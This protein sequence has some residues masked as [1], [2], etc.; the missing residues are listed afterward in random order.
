M[1][2]PNYLPVQTLELEFLN[3]DGTIYSTETKISMIRDENASPISIMGE[4]RDIAERKRIQNTLYES[5]RYYRALIE[6]A[7][8]CIL[9]VNME[10]KIRYQSPSVARNLGY[11]PDSLI[12]TNVFDLINPDDLVQITESFT[13][14]SNIPGSTHRGEYRF[15]HGNGEWCYL[16]IVSRYLMGDP[17]IAGIIINGRDITERK[18]AENALRESESKFHSLV[19]ESSDGIIISDELGRIV[20]FNN[21]IQQ[22]TGLTREAEIGRFLWD[23]QLQLRPASSQSVEQHELIKTMIQNALDTG[24]SP[25]LN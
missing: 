3:R 6:N 1:A 19:S 23:F 17:V 11:N 21:A 12:G 4:S 18:L 9:V 24:H 20:E 14:G 22:I 5:E 13:E 2:N 7:T 10:G 25:F 16:E 15:R 8:D